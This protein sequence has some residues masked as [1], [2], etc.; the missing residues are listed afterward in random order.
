MRSEASD[1]TSG[2]NDVSRDHAQSF[3][4]F[5]EKAYRDLLQMAK[6]HWRFICFSDY[7]QSGRAILW[8]HDIDFSIHR[9]RAL[10]KIEHEEGIC[11]TYFILLTGHFYNPLERE[12]AK[13]IGEIVDLGHAVGLHFDPEYYGS[14]LS[15]KAALEETLTFERRIMENLLGISPLAFSWHNPTSG[16]WL[17]IE[18]EAMA[19]MLNTYS[20]PISTRYRYVSD[21]N[22]VWRHDR[23]QD[24]LGD[25]TIE[26]LQVLTHPAWWVPE[27][28]APRQRIQR[29]AEGRSN[30]TM[31]RYDED[32]KRF[33]RPNIDREK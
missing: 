23:L 15:S 14:R 33:G 12:N 5:T 31:Q 21:S 6:K 18:D 19:G 2:K 8:R 22:G 25:A 17:T 3:G 9:A 32:M 10:A 27:A 30:R 24:V 7:A 13:I 20:K 16:D 26:K 1:M 28:M 11:S 4:D 29:T